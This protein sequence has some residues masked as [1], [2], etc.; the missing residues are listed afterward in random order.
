MTLT[1]KDVENINKIISLA[2][3]EYNVRQKKQEERGIYEL[4]TPENFMEDISDPELNKVSDFLETLT[5]EQKQKY[6]GVMYAGREIS[7]GERKSMEVFD[8][9]DGDT[10]AHALSEKALLHEYLSDGLKYYYEL[11]DG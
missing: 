4:Y 5:W 6:G 7:E 1:K 8:F 9:Y 2:E 10:G 11:S 3:Y